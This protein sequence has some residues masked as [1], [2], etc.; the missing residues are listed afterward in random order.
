M[1]ANPGKT[2]A[3]AGR[4]NGIRRAKK[5][6]VIGEGVDAGLLDRQP[7]REDRRAFALTLPPAGTDTLKDCLRRIA[8]HEKRM[9]ADF[10]AAERRTLIALLTRI[11]ARE[12]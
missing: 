3:A 11:E 12:R 7:A 9:L 10:S 5:V 8:A 2:K 4:A 1:S 6:R